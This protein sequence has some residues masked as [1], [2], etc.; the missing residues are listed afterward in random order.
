MELNKEQLQR[1]E[2]YLNLK[3]ITYIDV[4]LEV[5]DHIVSDI[6]TKMTEENLDF[7]TVFY[8][9]TNKWNTQLKETSSWLFGVGFSAPKI[10][11]EKAKKSFK[12][13]FFLMP[14]SYL[15]SYFL[16]N[17]MDF[18][19]SINIEN[20]LNLVFQIVTVLTV[21]LFVFL[22]ISKNKKRTTY[23]FIL[24]TQGLNILLGAILLIDFDFFNRK[25]HLNPFQVGLL[26]SFILGT[27]IYYHFYK[28]HQEAI[29]KYKIS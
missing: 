26:F 8:N 29:Q 3:N 15:L 9:V 27:Y 24:K 23:S 13:W 19:Y 4:R 22:L 11:L 10:I 12:K 16:I 2:H 28:K 20:S 18:L 1:V 14:A 7:E 5:L 6:E 25:G 21:V 17:K